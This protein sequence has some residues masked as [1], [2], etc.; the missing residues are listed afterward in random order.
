MTLKKSDIRDGWGVKNDS[1][2]SDIIYVCSPRY[3]SLQLSNF[4][5][6]LHKHFSKGPF[7]NYV[8]CMFA[9]F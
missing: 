1:K 4:G 9:H 3:E 5:L 2:K 6:G 7:V 8:S